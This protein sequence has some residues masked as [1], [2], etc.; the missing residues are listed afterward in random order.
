MHWLHISSCICVLFAY[1]VRVIQ[2][3]NKISVRF[4]HLVIGAKSKM[5]L[6]EYTVE[7]CRRKL[8]VIAC[9]FL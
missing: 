8:S 1:Q 7:A 6:D 5:F 2:V 3:H 9:M 4:V